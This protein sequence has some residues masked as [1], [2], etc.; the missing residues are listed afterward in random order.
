MNYLLWNWA[1]VLILFLN[2]LRMSFWLQ[3]IAFVTFVC[4]AAAVVVCPIHGW[5]NSFPWML[6][7]RDLIGCLRGWGIQRPWLMC[8]WPPSSCFVNS[9]HSSSTISPLSHG[10]LNPDTQFTYT[11]EFGF[12]WDLISIESRSS[13]PSS[14]DMPHWCM[15]DALPWSYVY[16]VSLGG[17]IMLPRWSACKLC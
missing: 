17:W 7:M 5:V 8:W 11:C 10:T 9:T 14:I 1:I 6:L 3:F 2:T 16:P 4:C 15:F 13:G 12:N